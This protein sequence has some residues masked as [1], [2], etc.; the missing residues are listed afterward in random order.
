M[1]GTAQSGKQMVG[2]VSAQH[3]RQPPGPFGPDKFCEIVEIAV[4]ALQH[5]VLGLKDMFQ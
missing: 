3:H 5:L 2:C 1:M 4:L